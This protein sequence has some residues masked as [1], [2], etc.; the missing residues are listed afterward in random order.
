MTTGNRAN[1]AVEIKSREQFND[2][3]SDE[4]TL[5]FDDGD[6]VAPVN[7]DKKPTNPH[8]T[9]DDKAREMSR[10]AIN[11]YRNGKLVYSGN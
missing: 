7:S 1:R 8:R 6:F 9:F 10:E 2:T 3:S 5:L 11:V 4:V